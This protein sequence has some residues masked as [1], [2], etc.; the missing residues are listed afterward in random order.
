ME[1][2]QAEMREGTSW[3][4]V[5]R[6]GLSVVRLSEDVPPMRNDDVL[7]LLLFTEVLRPLLILEQMSVETSVHRWQ[8]SRR[9]RLTC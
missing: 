4:Q 8:E 1:I 7:V 6:V 2:R 9:E 5:P 3:V